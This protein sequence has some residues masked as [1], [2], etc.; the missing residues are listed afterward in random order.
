MLA[1]SIILFLVGVLFVGLRIAIYKGKTDLIH[2]FHQTMVSD[3]A[4]YGNAFGKAVSV[5][6]TAPLISGI[7]SL[8]GDSDVIAMSAVAIL[9]VY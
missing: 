4:A 7:V 2:N 3:K 8:L 5:V 1:Y 6:S 9:N